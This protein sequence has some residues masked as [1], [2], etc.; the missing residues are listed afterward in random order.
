MAFNPFEAFR[1]N[2]KA[3]LAVLTIFIMF[4]F[5]LS[6]GG[7]GGGDFFDWVSR[8]F[9][10]K[11]SRGAKMGEI[12]GEDYYE[13]PLNEIRQQR[14]AANLFMLRALYHADVMLVSQIEADLKNNLI[15]NAAVREE[16]A[17][18]AGD[19]E[20]IL[21]RSVAVRDFGGGPT[22]VSPGELANAARRM[23]NSTQ[24]NERDHAAEIRNLHRAEKV[25][26]RSE[27]ALLAG[28][29][30]LYF[31]EIPNKNSEHAL[32]YL[33]ILKEAD[34]LELHFTEDDVKKLLHEETDG[35][36]DNEE[37]A[38]KVD[39][40]VRQDYKLSADKVLAAIGNEYRMRTM[41][42]IMRGSRTRPDAQTPFEMFEYYKDRCGKNRFEVVDISVEKYL[43][44]VKAEP[45]D[46]E[47]RE[48]YDTYAKVEFHPAR[49]TPGFKEPRK[50]G[51]EYIGIDDS[52]P[53]YKEVQPAL[54]QATLAAMSLQPG[55]AGDALS[56]A[57][58]AAQPLVAEPLHIRTVIDE[59]FNIGQRRRRAPFNAVKATPPKLSGLFVVADM[60]EA[61]RWRDYLQG[62]RHLD[63][64]STQFQTVPIP[65]L[66]LVEN[67]LGLDRWQFFMSRRR[68]QPY[69]VPAEPAIYHRLPLAS[70]T[71]QLAIATNPMSATA[72]AVAGLQNTS[73]LLDTRAR[74]ATGIQVAIAPL[75]S[76]P[77]F[78]FTSSAAA[79]ANVPTLN[80]QFWIASYFE[81][82]RESKDI[83]RRLAMRE[84][85]RLQERLNE[86]R[87][88]LAP[89]EEKKDDPLVPPPAPKKKDKFKAKDED[90]KK[91]NDEARALIDQFIKDHTFKDRP[92]VR[93]GKSEKLRHQ[94]DAHTDPGLKE[95]RDKLT[96]KMP[97]AEEPTVKELHR[98]FQAFFPPAD[99]KDNPLV[100]LYAPVAFGDARVSEFSFTDPTYLAW[101]IEDVPTKQVP[102]G[103]ITPEMK[104]EVVRAWKI[105]KARELAN[106]DAQKLAENLRTLAQKHLVES[107]NLSAFSGAVADLAIRD[108]KWK[109]LKEIEIALL[110]EK[111]PESQDPR[112]P[113]SPNTRS[114][115]VL[116]SIR[117]PEILYPPSIPMDQRSPSPQDIDDLIKGLDPWNGRQMALL[118]L[119]ARTKPLGETVIVKDQ[120]EMHVY[121]TVLAKK[122]PQSVASFYQVFKLTNGENQR[123]MFGAP[124][125]QFYGPFRFESR[126]NHERDLFQRI[127]AAVKFKETEELKKS[128]EKREGSGE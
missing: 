102:Y 18:V 67:L 48:L 85:N 66:N 24:L 124:S 6:S 46:K 39:A 37:V 117:T 27:A 13:I 97:G 31:V 115:F 92:S 59:D 93:T 113:P 40:A 51:I 1:K 17:K 114:T 30:G 83:E 108:D 111:L 8:Q 14:A 19:H 29:D 118:M 4:L 125:D 80:E 16:L 57:W 121:V 88:K 33:M 76:N 100:T 112:S 81:Q 20:S 94:F 35:V 104:A 91:A 5:V 52:L 105:Q 78:P 87:K 70:L 99:A 72:S 95:L 28:R 36:L 10:G 77:A 38:R 42:A 122:T 45:T 110:T 98:G 56:G 75:A 3:L 34:R 89:P 71:A 120:P 2:S 60:L 11:D 74:V 43:P 84:F 68:T 82:Q 25:Y 7:G 116:P 58:L 64:E 15:R 96:P 12:D 109:K 63:L 62:D 103:E 54:R 107:D 41:L 86:I 49:A 26:S 126:L 50:V 32:L 65:G 55:A 128:L 90:I 69:V 127:K 79:L 22:T 44:L 21:K 101:R 47:L 73:Q 53:L 119:E 9:G 61:R 106:E 123:S 23:A